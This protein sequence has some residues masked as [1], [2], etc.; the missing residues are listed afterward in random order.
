MVGPIVGPMVGPI[1]GPIVGP[2]VGPIVGL[3]VGP[4]VGPLT[5][6][7]HGREIYLTHCPP[8]RAHPW[9]LAG[10]EQSIY[11]WFIPA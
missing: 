2:M 8:F 11:A 5:E 10:F 7:P 1:V 4:I 6:E 9:L 3:K